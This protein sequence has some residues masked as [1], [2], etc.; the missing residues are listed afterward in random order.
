MIFRCSLLILLCLSLADVFGQSRRMFGGGRNWT[1]SKEP[2]SDRGGVPS[3][4]L[5]PEVPRDSFMWAR[6]KYRSWRQVR[7]WKWDTDFPDSDLNMSY[8]LHQLTAMR[9]DPNG[10]VVEITDP[11]LFDYPFLFM[12]GVGG[13]EFNDEEAA[14]MRRYML[15]GGFVF[16]DDFHG[17][18]QWNSFYKH[19]KK[20]FPDREP[21]EIPLEHPIFHM[22]YD[23]KEKP[24]VPNISIGTRSRG[25]QTWEEADWKEVH[26]CAI[27]DD[28]QRMVAFISHNSDLGDGWEEEATDPFYFITFSEPKA[29][30]IGFNVIIYAMTH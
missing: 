22:I 25:A 9:V 2:I 15:G 26:Y 8:R 17:H 18:Y 28:K 27:Y 21:I 14:I 3:W 23:L 7:S 16:F 24:Q 1:S 5:D 11:E 4:D 30:P 12:S 13:L 6:V 29:Y 20:V 19:I 10:T